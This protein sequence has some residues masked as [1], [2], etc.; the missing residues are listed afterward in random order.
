MRKRLIDLGAEITEKKERGPKPLAALVQERDRAADA[1]P[2][3]GDGQRDRLGG[4]QMEITAAVVP[5]N[6]RRSKSTR[7]S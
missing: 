3:G 2:E 7:S 5:E 1:D 6:S 4:R